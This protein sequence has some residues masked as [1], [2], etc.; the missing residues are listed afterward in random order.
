MLTKVNAFA[1]L[2]GHEKDVSRSW[3]DR[4]K[5]HHLIVCKK[6]VGEA[7]SVD[8]AVVD[9]WVSDKLPSVISGFD[10]IQR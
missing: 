10:H 2:L 1:N 4:W 9:E 8:S 3:I 6:L 7:T 5:A